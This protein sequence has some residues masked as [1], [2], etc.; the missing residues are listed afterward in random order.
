VT[1]EAG[2]NWFLGERDSTQFGQL[3]RND[4]AFVAVRYGF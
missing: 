3:D 4:N 2:L 1:V